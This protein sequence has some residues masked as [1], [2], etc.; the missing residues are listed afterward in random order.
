M[1]ETVWC[2][3]PPRPWR[4]SLSY[5]F[6]VLSITDG[7]ASDLHLPI[8]DNK[9]K[10]RKPFSALVLCRVRDF[11]WRLSVC[12]IALG[13]AGLAE[14]REEPSG[15]VRASERATRG[16]GLPLSRWQRRLRARSPLLAPSRRPPAAHPA[17]P[18]AQSFLCA[19]LSIPFSQSFH[20]KASQSSAK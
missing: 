20:C 17:S 15:A 14:A 2:L 16:R 8:S 7:A 9:D 13:A 4:G 1:N 3:P 12:E 6:H 19:T 5:R 18:P 10:C 11:R